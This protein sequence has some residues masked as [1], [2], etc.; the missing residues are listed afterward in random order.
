MQEQAIKNYR[1]EDY[2]TYSSNVINVPFGIWSPKNF[3][4]IKL[5][6]IIH[7]RTRTRKRICRRTLNTDPPLY[8]RPTKYISSRVKNIQL[9]LENP[10][11]VPAYGRLVQRIST[12]AQSLGRNQLLILSLIRRPKV[13]LGSHAIVTWIWY[14]VHEHKSIYFGAAESASIFQEYR[15]HCQELLL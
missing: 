14:H 3:I 7:F 12:N 15:I 10:V 1:L 13:I 6:D 11:T 8:Q 2:M 9:R 5:N 4:K